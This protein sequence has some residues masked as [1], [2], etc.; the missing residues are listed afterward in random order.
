MYAISYRGPCD[1]VAWQLTW[2][3][4]A[5]DHFKMWAPEQGFPAF[6]YATIDLGNKD[7]V[8]TIAVKYLKVLTKSFF[9]N[10][11]A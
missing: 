6:S 8:I 11:W 10:Q 7:Y 3:I 1:Q 9:L 2:F 4:V 5:Q